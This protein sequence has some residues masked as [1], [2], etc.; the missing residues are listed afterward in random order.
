MALFFDTAWFDQRLRVL[1]LARSN[2]AAAL[3]VSEA[4]VDALFK[5]QR[6]LAPTE[7]VTLAALL[8]VPV[9]DVVQRAGAGTQMPDEVPE[10]QP[11]A[12]GGF[13]DRLEAVEQAMQRLEERMN[14]VE[15]LL[16]RAV[17]TTRAIRAELPGGD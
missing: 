13:D 17:E 6:E 12:P 1:G 9:A 10:P 15:S 5:D 4:A 8:A 11:A 7:V 16:A 2:V 3:N 14:R